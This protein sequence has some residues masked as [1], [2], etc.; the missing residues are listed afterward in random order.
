MDAWT[1]TQ[2]AESLMREHQLSDWRFRFNRR[3]RAMGLCRYEMKTIELSIH[4]VLR[5]DQAQVVD[6][7]LHEI[8]HALAG[9]AAGHG[10]KW[11]RICRQIGASPQRCGEPVMP[12]GKWRA[13]CPSCGFEYSRYRRPPRGASYAC[14]DCGFERGKLVFHPRVGG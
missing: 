13:I 12:A 6:T 9:Y 7:I 4:F 10:A 11:R 3:K 8:A 5:N 14:S 1:A 2:L